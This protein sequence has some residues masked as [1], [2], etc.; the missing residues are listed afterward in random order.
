[1]IHGCVTLDEVFAAAA[2]RAASLV[3]ET[4]GYLALAVCDATSRLPF[5]VDDRLVMLTTE[6][7]VG[8]T[9]RGEVI[10]ARQAV[11]NLRA[12]LARLLSV[13]TG[14]SM[15]SLTATARPRDESDRGLDGLV[16]EIEAALI[17]VNRS[18]ARRALARLARE[19]IKAKESGRLKRQSA[20]R[21]AA[22]PR[23]APAPSPL[24]SLAPPDSFVLPKPPPPEPVPLAAAPVVAAPVPVPVV[25]APEVP[26]E[27]EHVADG[28]TTPPPGEPREPTPTVLGMAPVE[29]PE[30]DLHIDMEPGE[31]FP[32]LVAAPRVM[33]ESPVVVAPPLAMEPPEE[34]DP[35]ESSAEPGDESPIEIELSLPTPEPSALPESTVLAQ[36]T[37]DP[38]LAFGR[39]RRV[40][41]EPLA[42]LPE[43]A[44]PPPA[45]PVPAPPPVEVA[46]APPPP[47]P[48][49]PPAPVVAAPPPVEVAVAP[50][51]PPPPPP[52]PPAPE[53][54]EVAEVA[55]HVP[56]PVACIPVCELR[57][58]APPPP[59]ASREVRPT[60]AD[61]LLARFGASCVDEN[62]MR[63]AAACLRRIAGIEPTAP[64]SRVEARF[65]PTP[66]P[67]AQ[68]PV[69]APM[70]PAREALD[71]TLAGRRRGFSVTS[72]G[73]MLAVL[74]VGLAGGGA[75][76]WLRPDLFGALVRSVGGASEASPPAR[77]EPPAPPQ[78][79]QPAQVAPS[80]EPAPPAPVWTDRLG[81]TRAE[82][83][84]EQRAR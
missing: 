22:A 37:D 56:A 38:D 19:T 57:R 80:M 45:P 26:P 3:P 81:G 16:A 23:P 15:P 25:V 62:S 82:R 84:S 75:A 61:D 79:A 53:A 44:A 71:A 40:E 55:A 69:S 67:P 46:V 17:P 7:N 20:P 63:D 27:P 83:G 78:P 21:P 59:P 54:A 36:P 24:P 50:P 28:A 47:P 1:M 58:P 76:V 13:A 5:T 18:A 60:R 72:A 64:P 14:T 34:P 73:L 74:L 33:V 49:P 10:P 51:P 9:K 43:V 68:A 48:P 12:T 11:Q 66:P 8:I 41:V 70:P 2:V 4:S 52:A 35:W 39:P 77:P 42:L 29:I 31:V 30:V 32:P 6:G 65:A